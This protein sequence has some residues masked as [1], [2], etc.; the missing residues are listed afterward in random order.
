MIGSV[1]MIR[2]KVNKLSTWGGGIFNKE[3]NIQK[4][5]KIINIIPKKDRVILSFLGIF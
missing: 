5:N 4:I 3:L 1:N 2:T